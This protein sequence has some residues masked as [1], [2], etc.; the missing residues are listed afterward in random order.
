M[1]SASQDTNKLLLVIIS[2]L[3]PPV[4]V[5]LKDGF[6]FHFVLNLIL[7]VVT[8]YIGAIIHAIWRVLR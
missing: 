4:A 5:W 8:V 6:G 7:V 3:L 2:I 1:T